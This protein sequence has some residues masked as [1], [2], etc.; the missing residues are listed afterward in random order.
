MFPDR[1]TYLEEAHHFRSD[2]RAVNCTVLLS[3]D[4]SLIDDPRAGSRPYY[5]GSPPPI[6]WYREGQSVDLTNGTG[7]ASAPRMTG[8][9]FMTSLGHTTEFWQDDLNLQHIEAGCAPPFL[10]PCA[11]PPMRL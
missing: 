1:Y 10:G 4:E 5:Q 2:P 6:A 11:C 7:G 8:R 9:T 3:F